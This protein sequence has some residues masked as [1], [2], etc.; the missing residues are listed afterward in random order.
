MNLAAN[1]ISEFE[2]FRETP[3]WDV[4]AYRTGYGS[5]TITLPNGQVVAVEQGMRV[6]EED[7]RRDLARRV[8]EFQSGIVRDI[9]GD[10]WAQMNDSQQAALSS[11]AYNYG[12]LPDNVVQ[13]I[14]S[15]GDVTGA[16]RSLS[17]HNNGINY[18]RRNRE[19]DIFQGGTSDQAAP[20][21]TALYDAFEAGNMSPEDAELFQGMIASGEVP[22][23]DSAKPDAPEQAETP[24]S[25]VSPL[26]VY[27]AYVSG[28][29]TPEDAQTFEGMLS[30]GQVLAPY[31]NDDGLTPPRADVP[32]GFDTVT[33]VKPQQR[34]IGDEILR[35]LGLTARAGA[36][37]A[38]GILGLAYDPIASLL[39]V[40][41]SDENQIAPL[42][43]QITGLLKSAGV[44][45]PENQSERIVQAAAESMVGAGGTA[46]LAQGAAGVLTKPVSKAVAQTMAKGAGAQVTGGA[47]AG[48]GAQIAAENDLGVLGQ[49]GGALAGGV[50]GAKLAPKAT[51][52]AA[53]SDLAEQVAKSEAQ[54]IPVMTSDILPPETF[55]AKWLQ[56]TGEMVP[57]AGTGP[58]RAA[59]QTKRVDAIRNLLRDFG[60][61]DAANLTDDVM[62]DLATKRS[63][64][65]AKY[66]GAKKEVFDAVR[67]AGKVPVKATMTAI[68]DQ[69]ARL[70]SLQT[71]DVLPVIDRLEDWKRSIQGQD[72]GNIELIRKQMGE[73]FTDPSLVGVKNIGQK[74][75]NSIYPSLRN[76]MGDF[77]KAN[78]NKRDFT[79]WAVANKRLSNLAG[80]LD[81]TALKSALN[82]GTAT[83]EMVRGLLFSK[84]PSDVKSLYKNLTPEGR[85]TARAAVLQEA[86]SKSAVDTAT[87]QT[88]SPAKFATQVSKMGNQVG[89]LFSGRDLT[90][91]RGLTRALN[92]TQRANDAA[93]SPPTGVQ[94]IP[95]IG[96]AALTDI[97]GGFGAALGGAGTIGGAA[98]VYESRPVRN[99]LIA[100]A[101]TKR[102]STEEAQ[103]LKRVIATAQA[104]KASSE[105]SN[106]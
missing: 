13:A 74:A 8:P 76:D 99:A 46:K 14:A 26:D 49:L 31:K 64:D 93:V 24:E 47:G 1:L 19:A 75:L 15:G 33:E 66:T 61:D 83:P 84:K 3:Y 92:L 16:I 59:Q 54:G 7:A 55:A 45:E 62:K 80:E 9:G 82:K 79:K 90:A 28:A 91:V 42:R 38:G 53:A 22:E 73:A 56:K 34:G 37:G 58:V 6:N 10:A 89:I 72:I 36:Q 98:R 97:L 50:L 21:Y 67:L 69:V 32:E 71:K 81:K 103:I 2:G 25:M 87:G 100:M 105:E 51:T 23:R 29:M 11:I 106:Q 43:T 86:L 96:A 20:D 60:A 85:K 12:S 94:A 101:K 77:I 52:P 39:N 17:S 27:K 35:Q 48:A 18:D 41:L 57:I 78:G 44:P 4:N 63:A 88:I 5:D 104:A 40:G 65:I 68:D 70:K 30:S 102:G 95:A